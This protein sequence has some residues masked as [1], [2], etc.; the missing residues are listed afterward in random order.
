[1]DNILSC[2]EKEDRVLFAYLLSPT[3][4]HIDIDE[5]G[6]HLGLYLS[7]YTLLDRITGYSKKITFKLEQEIHRPITIKILNQMDSIELYHPLINAELII[8]RDSRK[9][10][11]FEARLVDEHARSKAFMD[12]IQMIQENNTSKVFFKL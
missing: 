7:H 11:S 4:T 1:L 8:K 6:I 5:Q 9:W 12:M 3:D 10:I 2:I